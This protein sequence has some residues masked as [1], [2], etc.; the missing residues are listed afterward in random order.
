MGSPRQIVPAAATK[1]LQLAGGQPMEQAI[2]EDYFLGSMTI[3]AL[4]QKNGRHLE[5]LLK[6]Y[7]P[8]S[9]VRA[10]RPG[11]FC[12]IER[13]GVTSETFRM[14]GLIDEER[15]SQALN[16]SNDS[17]SIIASIK[18]LRKEIAEI[19][20][21]VDQPFLG[22]LSGLL[23]PG[24]ARF[25]E[26]PSRQETEDYSVIL[27]GVVGVDEFEESVESLVESISALEG[28]AELIER[29]VRRIE[30]R[31][32]ETVGVLE[33]DASPTLT[34]LER[35]I[36]S[37]E[38]QI[39]SLE[40]QLVRARATSST[41]TKETEIE[42]TLDARKAALK[43]DLERKSKIT[44]KIGKSSKE[45]LSGVEK[46]REE[47]KEA[48]RILNRLERD[49]G[50]IS[51]TASIESQGAGTTLLV[52]FFFV[53]YSKKGL[54][55]IRVHPPANLIETDER[56]GRRRGFVDTFSSSS[57][58][59]D[60]L[61][62][63]LEEHANSDVTFRK[64]IRN[65]SSR[66]NLLSLKSSRR[67][68]V[69]GARFLVADGLLKP[70]VADDLESMISSIPE[71]KLR[72]RV[73][74][75]TISVT[76]GSTCRVQFH[77]HDETGR[78]VESAEIE[79]GALVLDSDN[80]GIVETFL[81]KSRYEGVVKARGYYDRQF[82]FILDSIDDITI[83]IV[84]S[85]LSHEEQISARLDELVERAR[86]LDG[87]RERLAE[88]F[89]EQGDTLLSIPAYRSAL[90]ELL[91]EL[92]YEPESWIASARRQGGMVKRLLKRDDRRDALRRDILRT[93]EES[94]QSGGIMLL[95]ELLVHLDDLGWETESDEIENIINDMAQ[96]GLLQG[97]SRLEGGALLVEFVPVALTDDPQLLLGLAAE[98][99][100]LLSIEDAVVGLNWT[101]ERVRNALSLLVDSGVAKEQRSY[102][103]STQYWFPGLRRGKEQT[104]PR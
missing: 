13:V 63:L 84:L 4:E 38:N 95:S 16:D 23:A 91:T 81:P 79:L 88:A 103:K 69:D 8:I 19:A 14:I 9:L 51:V 44:G 87:I 32:E 31:V 41:S 66:M 59:V 65:L 2:P 67:L 58:A 57:H 96:E 64:R 29:T 93:A 39:E 20:E 24:V 45:M 5:F 7:V 18:L 76:D 36:E 56:I 27:P 70:E 90:A 94:K 80:R 98:R 15:V 33:E 75:P 83:P 42:R 37:L 89:E 102:S 77:V 99:D 1:K 40:S 86:R 92:G 12:L 54:L 72:K 22:L 49:L 97:I 62:A 3:R 26:R 30:K 34:R 11:R 78:P 25:L 60:A 17:E 52:P 47:S 50:N 100:G 61:C 53:G 73:R 46:L 74:R 101:E 6:G 104:A 71:G 35:R 68:I 55:E 43:R 48:I 21:S 28:S 85:P 82:E 10:A